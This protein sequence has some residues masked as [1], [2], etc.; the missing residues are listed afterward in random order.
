M[1]FDIYV[2]ESSQNRHRYLLLGGVIMPTDNVNAFDACA[3]AARGLD[4]P[5]GEMGWVKVS[6]TKLPAYKRFVEAFFRKDGLPVLDFHSIVIDASQLDD[7][8]YNGG[9]R[10]AGF[11]KEI[12]QLI[13]KFGRLYRGHEFDVYLDERS[14]PTNLEELR[15]IVNHGMRLNDPSSRWPVRR[16][17]FRKGDHCHGLQIVDVLL[18]S[19]AFHLNGHR[20]KAD[21]SA[22]KCELSDYVLHLARIADVRRDTAVKGRFTIW[23]RRLKPR[24]PR[25]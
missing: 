13:Q 22:A 12:Y 5:E 3:F 23:H 1:R 17:H 15:T 10:E 7:R 24:S 4:L 6:R 16:L 21:A 11:N 14:T 20:V 8:Q 9:S 19:V 18:G 2:D 25:R